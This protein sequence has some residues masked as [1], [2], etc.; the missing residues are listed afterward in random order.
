MQHGEVT[1]PE[2]GKTFPGKTMLEWH[3]DAVH[4]VLATVHPVP[5]AA[6]QASSY[7][8]NRLTANIALRGKVDVN[9]TALFGIKPNPAEISDAYVRPKKVFVSL[10]WM[11]AWTVVCVVAIPKAF[12]FN[13]EVLKLYSPYGPIMFTL[14]LG[15][16]ELWTI[17]RFISVVTKPIKWYAIDTPEG[18]IAHATRTITKDPGDSNAFLTRG[19]AHVMLDEF[20]DAIT[21]FDM[22]IDLDPKQVSAYIVR[23]IVHRALNEYGKAALD[24]TKAIDFGSD[25]ELQAQLYEWRGALHDLDRNHAAAQ[26]DYEK[27][28]ELAKDQATVERARQTVNSLQFAIERDQRRK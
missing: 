25:D 9:E 22:A 8:G 27:V 12:W 23:G 14:C 6:H 11:V 7:S 3:H 28:L 16:T 5:G 15:W 20:E 13:S 2:C 21:D 17:K 24:F 18:V 1:C 19:A 4:S 10:A 26:A